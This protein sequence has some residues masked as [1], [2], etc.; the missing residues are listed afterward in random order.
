MRSLVWCLSLLLPGIL[1]FG[2]NLSAGADVDFQLQESDVVVFAGG[3]NMVRLQRAGYLEAMLTLQYADARPMFRD[4]AWEADTVYRQ[5]TVIERWRKDGYRDV[6]GFGDLKSQLRRVDATV[7]VAQFGRLESMNGVQEIDRFTEAYGRLIETFQ[8][9]SR[10]VILVTPTPFERSPG[11]DAPRLDQRNGDLA[12]YVHAIRRIS[13]ERQLLCIDLFTGADSGLTDNGMHVRPGAQQHVAEVIARQLGCTAGKA[14]RLESLRQAVI[15]KHRLWYDY[16]RPANWKLLSGDDAKRQFTRGGEDSLPFRQEWQTLE[17]LIHQAEKRVWQIARGGADPGPARPQPEVLHGD[18]SADIQQELESFSLPAGLRVNLFASER[19]GLTSPLNI[20]WDPSGRMYVTVTTTY[21]HVFPGDVPNDK[22]IVLEDSDHDGTADRST[23]F[24]EGLN[25][26]T[27]IEVGDGGVY[28]GQNTELLFLKDTDG[29]GTS[30]RRQVVLGGFGNGDSH[31]TINSFVWSPDGELYFGHGDGCESRVETPWGV[32][33]LFNAGF[34]RLRPRRLQLIPFL[35]SHMCAGNPWGV[36]FD[37][38]G[39]AFS[40][41]GAGG[42]NWLT[43]GLVSTTHV[44]R[45]RRIGDP[46]GYCG[47]A[48]LDGRHLPESMQ[49]DFVVGDFKANRVR[50]FSLKEN[51]TGFELQWKK[52]VLQS[53]HRNFRPVDVKVGPDGAIYVVDWYNPITCHQDDAYRHPDRDKAHGRIWRIATDRDSVR[54]PDLRTASLDQVL[55]AL[56]SP[57]SW[58]RYQAKR[59]LTER[60]A[61]QVEQALKTWVRTLDPKDR[62]HEHHLFEALGACATLELVEP[63]LLDR[64]LRARDPRARAFACRIVGRWSDRLDN[65]LK[66]LAVGVA[67]SHPRVRMEAVVACSAIP[68]AESIQV[69]ARVVDAPVD[70]WIQ[71]ALS[72]TVHHLKPY[73]LPAFRQGKISFQRPGQM[74]AVLNETGGREVLESLR[75]LVDTD[76]LE[77]QVR[78]SAIKAILAVGNPSDLDEYGLDPSRF[79]TRSGKYDVRR[80]AEALAELIAVARFRDVRPA[81]NP[82]TRL[83][84][85]ISRNEPQLQ[86]RALTLA[87]IWKLKQT[88]TD[89]LKAAGDRTL[90]IPVRAAAFTAIVE[91]GGSDHRDLLTRY[92]GQPHSQEIR[93]AAVQALI[94][95]DLQNAA[96]FAAVLFGE[97]DLESLDAGPLLVEFLSRKDGAAVLVAALQ[98]MPLKPET[99]QHMLRTLLST[100]RSDRELFDV[101]S[102]ASGRAAV[103]PEYSPEFVN[104]LVAAARQQGKAEQGAVLFKSL[105]CTACHRVRGSGSGTGPDLTAIGT[106]LSTERIVEE[107]LWPERQIKEGFTLLSVVTTQGRVHTGY[108]RRTRESRQSGD[109]ILQDVRTGQVTTIRKQLVDETRAGGSAMP[110]GV[111]AFLSRNQL[112]DLIRYLSGLG[113]L[114]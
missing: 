52:P 33:E 41:D 70:E 26:P 79:V 8:Q 102:R 104:S 74:A 58:T 1:L 60:D 27:G 65:P 6:K 46:G 110:Q 24:A 77:E 100:G 5:G 78:A 4:F 40:V 56:A 49:G 23:V 69:A 62:H 81:G 64:V 53:R 29:D 13:R 113:R 97:S 82:V 44:R 91:L 31:Q 94:A 109:I 42:V 68:S 71:Y 105:A 43:P 72:Q 21:P 19:E 3:T 14:E 112:L 61:G 7:V 51:G 108:E 85:L 12:E 30:D 11:P 96:H 66:L 86:A 103:I 17:P 55:A 63:Q 35:E 36:A 111:T 95:V 22:I 18:S 2:K 73:W 50:R 10:K 59:A 15:E 39:Q 67:D 93:M 47:I 88:Q 25:I 90:A 92:A 32:S 57:E 20:R 76:A 9:N 48:C 16:W 87:G 34:Y 98:A 83:R 114:E 28:V 99:A 80:H 89:V 75:Q 107:L 45:I 37:D 101:L 38:W 84:E 54:P 106:T